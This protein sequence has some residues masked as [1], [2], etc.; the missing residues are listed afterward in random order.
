VRR[1][2]LSNSEAVAPD[3]EEEGIDVLEVHLLFFMLEVFPTSGTFVAGTI[4]PCIS[5]FKG[6]NRTGC[7]SQK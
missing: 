4:D 6:K 3:K 2:K 5:T 7:L 1:P